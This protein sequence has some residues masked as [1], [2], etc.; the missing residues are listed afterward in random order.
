MPRANVDTDIE[1]ASTAVPLP[2]SR[3]R[4]AGY[5][6]FANFIAADPDAA[7]YR[8]YEHLS[9]R[10]LLYLQSELHDLEA[11]LVELDA[12]DVR[13][14]DDEDEVSKKIARYWDY[15]SKAS[16]ERAK[17]HRALQKKISR[18]IKEYR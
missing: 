10:N 3:S 11:Q 18:K 17:R 4:L 5:P 15:Y 14:K 7:I 1:L 8:K 12:S 9:A 16:S 2:S 13:K 6:T